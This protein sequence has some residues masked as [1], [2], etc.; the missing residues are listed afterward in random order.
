M[1]KRTLL[2]LLAIVI[3]AAAAAAQNAPPPPNSSENNVSG[4]VKD[5]AGRPL[6]GATLIVSNAAGPVQ[7][8]LTNPF[9]Y[10][11]FSD[12]PAGTYR[13]EIKAKGHTFG[14]G[15]SGIVFDFPGDVHFDFTADPVE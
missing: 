9:G 8:A 2:C 4:S 3:F 10:Y 14:S 12:L 11:V 7:T 15:E 13:L 1:M 6:T 5:A